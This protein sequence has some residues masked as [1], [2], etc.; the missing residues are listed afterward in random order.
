VG[1]KEAFARCMRKVHVVPGR[2][3]EGYGGP[4]YVEPN[5]L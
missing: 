1:P 3:R 4:V 2:P 5:Y